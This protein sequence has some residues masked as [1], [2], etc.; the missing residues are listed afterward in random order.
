MSS[1]D[2]Q[3]QGILDTPAGRERWDRIRSVMVQEA[4]AASACCEGCGCPLHEATTG[5]RHRTTDAGRRETVCS[6]C[7]FVGMDDA[8]DGLPA[9]DAAGR[10]VPDGDA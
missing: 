7:F 3:P 9:L 4:A 2:T 10:V 6:D 8:D 1:Q 5:R